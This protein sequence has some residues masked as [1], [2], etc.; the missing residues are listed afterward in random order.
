MKQWIAS[1]LVIGAVYAQTDADALRF[2]TWHLWSTARGTGVNNSMGAIGAD[3]VSIA[4]NPAGL[5][6]YRL[7]DVMV[8][9]M[10]SGTFASSTYLG[11]S[12]KA[13]RYNFGVANFA[14]VSTGQKKDFEGKPRKEGWTYVNWAIGMNRLADFNRRVLFVGTNRENSLLDVYQASAQGLKPDQLDPFHAGLAWNAYLLNPADSDTTSY[15]HVASRAPL[16]QRGELTD[17]GSLSDFYLAIAGD[18]SHKMFVGGSVDLVYLSYRRTFRYEEQDAEGQLVDFERFVLNRQVRTEG[19]GVMARFGLLY[20]L[21]I[22]VRI[23]FSMHSPAFISLKD[24]YSAVLESELDTSGSFT[25][26]SPTGTFSYKLVT[27]WRVGAHIGAIIGKVAFVNLDY[28]FV[29]YSTMFFEFGGDA[30]ASAAEA[31]INTLIAHKYTASHEVR[32]G[33]EFRLTPWMRLRAGWGMATSPFSDAYRPLNDVPA[34]FVS[35]GLGI[36]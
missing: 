30:V 10:I 18:Y 32:L 26:Q 24:K 3:P 21:P 34:T 19:T 17:R 31:D 8:T 33:A 2:S 22:P 27:P 16:L 23:G 25:A 28:T 20:W 9:P 4:Q 1:I 14:I 6:L 29:D 15:V 12:T 5:G 36:R 11:Q 7:G 35:G 13:S